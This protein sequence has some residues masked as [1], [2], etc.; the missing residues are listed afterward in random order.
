MADP[1]ARS[2]PLQIK[3]DYAFDRLLQS[4]LAQA[5]DILVPLRERPVGGRIKEFDDEDGGDLRKGLVRAATRGKHDREPDGVADR[6]RQEPRLGVSRRRATKR[7]SVVPA[8]SNIK[9]QNEKESHGHAGV[10]I[11]DLLHPF[12]Q[13]FEW[14]GPGHCCAR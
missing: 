11:G 2:S 4:K 13:N 12:F 10:A 1:R 6:V 14:H 9:E 3:V 8:A 7:N 5:Y